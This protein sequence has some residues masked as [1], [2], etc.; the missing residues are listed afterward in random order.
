MAITSVRKFQFQKEK[1]HSR[2]YNEPYQEVS[3]T[4]I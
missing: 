1:L 2:A 4:Q 3:L